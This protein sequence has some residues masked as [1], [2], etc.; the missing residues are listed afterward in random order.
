MNTLRIVLLTAIAIALG[1]VMVKV[2]AH[3]VAKEPTYAAYSFPDSIPI[4]EWTSVSHQATPAIH[5]EA[6]KTGEESQDSDSFVGATIAQ[7]IYR[8]QK[9]NAQLTANVQYLVQTNSDLKSLMPT[10]VSQRQVKHSPEH[11]FYLLFEHEG[12][13]YLSACQS[14]RG[15]TAVSTDQFNRSRMRHDV[16]FTRVLPWLKGESTLPDERCLWTRLSVPIEDYGSRAIAYEV[17]ET[18]WDDWAEW[19]KMNFPED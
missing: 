1:S 17:I 16:D 10:Q 14:Q 7:Q 12:Y 18:A 15:P 13:A 6:A 4:D 8:Y 9:G 3:P 2:V 11:G 19:W 5:H